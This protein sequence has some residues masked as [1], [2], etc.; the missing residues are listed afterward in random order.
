MSRKPATAT[1][2]VT[3]WVWDALSRLLLAAAALGAAL[4]LGRALWLRWVTPIAAVVVVGDTEHQ[5]ERVLRPYL[6]AGV[7]GDFW[8]S[9]LTAVAQALADAPWVRSAV[10]A[11]DYPA[12]LRVQIEEHRAVAWW[13]E[14][15]GTRLVND[16]GEIFEAPL[17][18]SGSPNWPVLIG[19]AQRSSEVLAAYRQL[20]DGLRDGPFQVSALE[21]S[22]HGSWRATLN[23]DLSL[24]LGRLDQAEWP[25]RLQRMNATLALLRQRYDQAL[26]SID[27]RYPNGFAVSLRGV[28]VGPK[29]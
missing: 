10:V 18:S 6:Q 23:D 4:L 2:P 3:L 7:R 24:V 5:S 1:A 27:L 25:T 19:P 9:D 28:T 15:K 14:A 29:L 22:P 12:R 17:E 20:S 13:G 8:R 16:R 26:R 11:R 21:L